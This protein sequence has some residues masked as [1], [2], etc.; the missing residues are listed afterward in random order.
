MKPSGAVG[1]NWGS[2]MGISITKLALILLIVLVVF[3]AGRLP[4][5]MSDIGK[6]L[7]ALKDGISGDEKTEAEEKKKLPES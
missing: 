6:G 3:G 4:R 7:R 1:G 2:V 5:V